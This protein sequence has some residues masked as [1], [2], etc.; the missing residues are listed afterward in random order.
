[1]QF[2]HMMATILNIRNPK[3]KENKMCM[4]NKI[5]KGTPNPSMTAEDLKV[6]KGRKDIS[7]PTAIEDSIH[8]M[9]A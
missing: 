3:R 7:V 5:R 4:K 2:L 9:H 8:N 1:M 6:E